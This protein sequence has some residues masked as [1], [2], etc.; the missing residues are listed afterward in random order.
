[1]KRN[2]AAEIFSERIR[3]WW[4]YKFF[5]RAAFKSMNPCIHIIFEQSLIKKC[6]QTTCKVVAVVMVGGGIGP[7]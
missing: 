1:M 4:K 3:N 6:S 7:C 5:R 2:I